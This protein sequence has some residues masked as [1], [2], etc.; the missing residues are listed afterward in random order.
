M[1]ERLAGGALIFIIMLFVSVS[2]VNCSATPQVVD[3][4]GGTMV[5]IDHT[6]QAKQVQQEGKQPCK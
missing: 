6:E 1:N 3:E 2:L 5:V 4:G